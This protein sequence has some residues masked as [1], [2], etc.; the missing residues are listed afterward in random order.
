VAL[1]GLAETLVS[2][3]IELDFLAVKK[4]AR[5][6]PRVVGQRMEWAK[7]LQL[8]AMLARQLTPGYLEDG[9]CGLRAMP[10][11]EIRR[12]LASFLEDAKVKILEAVLE[13]KTA[14]GSRSAHEA[15]SKFD[16]FQGNFASI[17]D[18]HAG[19]EAVLKLGYPNPDIDKGI[20]LE[21]TKH[22]CVTSLFVTPN[23][24]IATCLLIE[25]A[26][27]VDPY[28]PN[29]DALKLLQ[30]RADDGNGA[31]RSAFAS[32]VASSGLC[33]VRG[34]SKDVDIDAGTQTVTFGCH[35]ASPLTPAPIAHCP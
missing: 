2:D 19:A 35:P 21:H 31:R 4:A 11:Q 18:F 34:E 12:A 14:K 26:W 33:L 8:D 13:A 16:G 28:A 29:S 22:S 10:S 9:L 5:R 23:Y 27:A 24:R 25:Y 30:R 32:G 20:L 1:A 17:K 6:V 7:G 3:G 15:N